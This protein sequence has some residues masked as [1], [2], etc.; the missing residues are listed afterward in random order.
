MFKDEADF[1]KIVGRLEIDDKP[2]PA[3]R[4]E[5]R[6]RMLAVF[7]ECRESPGRQSVLFPGWA[8]T[9]L[10]SPIVK[11]AVAAAV[12][13][14]IAIGFYQ[15]ISPHNGPIVAHNGSPHGV[16]TIEPVHTGTAGPVHTGTPGELVPIEIELPRPIHNG[17]EK[18]IRVP[19]LK[20]LS[21]RPRPAFLAPSGTRNVAL[22]KPVTGSEPIFGELEMI[23]DGDKEGADGS[24]VELGPYVQHVTIDLGAVHEIYAVVVWHFH[25]RPRVYFD[26]VVQL[27]DDPD[28]ITNVRTIFNN[29]IDNSAGLGVGEDMHYVETNQGNLI[30]AHG[31]KAR[32][33]RLYSNGNNENGMNHYIEVEVYGRS[34][35]KGAG[36]QKQ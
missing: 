18:D 17:T 35:E 2:D 20:K 31:L 3:H 32:Y 19:H 27:A 30:D 8:G 23:T 13:V 10:R 5:L 16:E 36:P 9:L 4:L 15:L 29:D 26:V 28:F 25:K 21:S 1:V 6:R 22:G 14:G 12:L 7:A 34:V 11:L 24:Y 33:V